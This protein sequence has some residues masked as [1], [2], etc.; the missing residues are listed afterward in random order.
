MCARFDRIEEVP[1]GCVGAVLG[2]EKIVGKTG[3]VLSE[4]SSYPLRE[5]KMEVSPVV[6]R[7]ISTD[8]ST[9]K[10]KLKEALRRVV[11]TDSTL[12]LLKGE[13]GEDVL[14]ATGE[15]HLEIAINN[16]KRLLPSCKIITSQPIVS[17]RET[18]LV[19][20][21]GPCLAKSGN[22]LNRVWITAEPLSEELTAA[23]ENG[24]IRVDEDMR[25]VTRRRQ[26]VEQYGFEPNDAARVWAFGP[27]EG[28]SRSNMLVDQ[29][30][31]AQYLQE[32]KDSIV[33]AFQ[34]VCS[35]GVLMGEQLRGVRFNLT[36]VMIHSDPS[37]RGA[38]EIIPATRRAMYAAM[39]T[40][41]P[42]LQEPMA[43]LHVSVTTAFSP[44]IHSVMGQK[45]GLV[46][47]ETPRF[48]TPQV[49]MEAEVPFANS[50]GLNSEISEK[51]SGNAFLSLGFG[52][53]Q[54][55]NNDPL[56]PA[57]L[58]G[59][60]VA[61]ARIRRRLPAAVPPLTQFLDKL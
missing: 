45:R 21:P 34:W 28:S 44:V 9:D 46:L 50:F 49:E 15:L 38:K 11:R 54:T 2:I 32:V 59:S 23:I 10:P 55:I 48:G 61:Q 58:S 33:A 8:S 40:A 57:T 41:S 47:S 56:D 7:A 24:K 1:A 26:L 42:A 52:R 16:L 18:I 29:T 31:G 60:Y 39:L 20:S 51:T 6:R 4:R 14:A 36:D 5:M 3:T 22:K 17:F 35:E 53:W 30:T 25:S 13:D 19:A 37:H 43:A 12:E 27:E